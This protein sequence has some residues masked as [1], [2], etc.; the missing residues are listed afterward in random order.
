MILATLQRQHARVGRGRRKPLEIIGGTSLGVELSLVMVCGVGLVLEEDI[1]SNYE[2]KMLYIKVNYILMPDEIVHHSAGND[3]A[4][5][6]CSITL[7]NHLQL[8]IGVFLSS[9]N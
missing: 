4:S 1:E 3:Q 2:Q 9:I 8:T 6:F 5:S 7:S